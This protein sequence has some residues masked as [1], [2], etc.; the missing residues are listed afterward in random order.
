MMNKELTQ[1]PEYYGLYAVDVLG[2]VYSVRYKKPKKL[3][4][5]KGNNGYK[6]VT[7][8]VGGSKKKFY[9]RRLMAL[10][11]LD[12]PSED[13]TVINLNGDP[14]DDRLINLQ[15]T[16]DTQVDCRP[17]KATHVSLGVTKTYDSIAEAKREGFN[18]NAIIN[19]CKGK[20]ET[21]KNYFWKY[22]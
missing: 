14:A 18:P 4:P 10:T 12:K 20:Q 17:V 7:L 13:A 3:K 5:Q 6:V 21:Y 15:W 8:C 22:L 2:N 11:F 19:C 1:I 9:V 16:T